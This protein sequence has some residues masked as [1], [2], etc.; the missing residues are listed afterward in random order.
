MEL[1]DPSPV[2]VYGFYDGDES[3]SK[4]AFGLMT[5]LEKKIGVQ[6]VGQRCKYLMNI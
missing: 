2:T 3:S 6:G 1:E 4:K 5:F